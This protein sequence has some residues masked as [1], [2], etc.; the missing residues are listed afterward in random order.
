MEKKKISDVVREARLAKGYKKQ[1]DLAE[2][3]GISAATLS[4]IENNIHVPTTETLQK[5]AQ[6]LDLDYSELM[7]YAGHISKP[8]IHGMNIANQIIFASEVPQFDKI[9]D[10][11]LLLRIYLRD[12]EK[13]SNANSLIQE[14]I[15]NIINYAKEI[16]LPVDEENLKQ[17]PSGEIENL[18]EYMSRVGQ[19][20]I[21]VDLV[22][23][24]IRERLLEIQDWSSEEQESF[25]SC[26][27]KSAEERHL[28]YD[29]SHSTW[30]VEIQTGNN[31]GIANKALELV[32]TCK[33]NVKQQRLSNKIN[34]SEFEAFISNP[35]NNL[36]FKE[37]IESP[38][39][40]I[41]DL[42]KVWE[43]IKRT[44]EDEKR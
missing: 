13:L 11:I 10:E 14:H 26:L 20:W 43:I 29:K 37:L 36:F 16:S 34:T 12:S 38:E 7:Y 42:R 40:R 35:E 21:Q 27:E 8:I 33:N 24:T 30:L 22:V 31:P 3:S 19:E 18:M 1:K 6:F 28:P 39:K 4:R 9:V 17:N 44:T 2:V 32:D 25:L 5:L 41:E 23:K 15:Q